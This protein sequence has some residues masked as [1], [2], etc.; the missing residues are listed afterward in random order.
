MVVERFRRGARRL[1][2]GVKRVGGGA[3]RAGGVLREKAGT[4]ARK[5]GS[6][7]RRFGGGLLEG[8]REIFSRI[9]RFH[10]PEGHF[11][12]ARNEI[13]EVAGPLREKVERGLKE[14][15]V[16]AVAETSS[17]WARFLTGSLLTTALGAGLLALVPPVGIAIAAGGGLATLYSVVK[18]THERRRK[19]T[20]VVERIVENFEPHEKFAW[21]FYHVTGEDRSKEIEE[22]VRKVMK[23]ERALARFTQIFERHYEMSKDDVHRHDLRAKASILGGVAGGVAGV[24]AA[25]ALKSAV[26]L[27]LGMGLPVAGIATA[28]YFASQ[29]EKAKRL[30]RERVFKMMDVMRRAV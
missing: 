6:G 30:F 24:G 21:K 29:R 26:L 22:I 18:G 25:A 2:E 11:E 9:A 28:L 23:G 7:A 20:E 5:V 13:L 14:E 16:R 12:V 3:S 1:K 15:H 10:R 4:G 17:S 8:F 19:A 27:G